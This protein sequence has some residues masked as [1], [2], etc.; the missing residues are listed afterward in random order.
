MRQRLLLDGQL[1]YIDGELLY[2]PNNLIEP[3]V[4]SY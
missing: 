2:A 3:E 4:A 1:V